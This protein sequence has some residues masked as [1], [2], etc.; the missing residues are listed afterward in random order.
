MKASPSLTSINDWLVT[1]LLMYPAVLGYI[2]VNA[3]TLNISPALVGWMGVIGVGVSVILNRLD[4]VG[5][6][7]AAQNIVAATTTGIALAG[8]LPQSM[9]DA[10]QAAAQPN[11]D[12]SVVLAQ[13]NVAL[14]VSQVPNRAP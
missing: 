6:G 1:F 4:T 12:Q 9:I 5:A 11:V 3:A 2:A 13:P 14:P 8:G 7:P 10:V